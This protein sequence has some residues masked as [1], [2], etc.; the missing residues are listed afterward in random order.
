MY[1]KKIIFFF[2]GF[3]KGNNPLLSL[4]YLIWERTTEM[5]DFENR[6]LVWGCIK[7]GKNAEWLLSGNILSVFFFLDTIQPYLFGFRIQWK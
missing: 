6:I 2:N 4:A 3:K 1:F 7:H 5:Y